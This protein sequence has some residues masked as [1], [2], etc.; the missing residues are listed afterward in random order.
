MGSIYVPHRNESC[1][2]QGYELPNRRLILACRA[3][4]MDRAYT[5]GVH[6]NAG[7]SGVDMAKCSCLLYLG[8]D[9]P[10]STVNRYDRPPA[11]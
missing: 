7:K 1:I 5:Y 6:V 3:M 9:T 11:Q 8:L 4:G 2:I 10:F